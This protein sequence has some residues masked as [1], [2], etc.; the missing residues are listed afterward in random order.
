M[1]LFSTKFALS[2][3]MT[4]NEFLSMLQDWMEK[5]S[6]YTINPSFS[7]GVNEYDFCSEDKSERLLVYIMDDTLSVRL[8]KRNDDSVFTNTYIMTVVDGI[9]VMFIRLEKSLL[10]A[11]FQRDFNMKIPR[12]MR[13]I[14]WHEYGG[15]DHGL[16]T[17]D[18]SFILRK[19][20]VDLANDILSYNVEFFNPIVYVSTIK[21]TGRYILNYDVLASELLGMAHVVVEGSPFVSELISEATDGKNPT[22][23]NVMVLLPSGETEIFTKDYNLNNK[24]AMYIRKSMADVLVDD[25]FSFSKIRLSYLLSKTS[26]TEELSAICDEI[27][28]DKDQEIQAL[29]ARLA[30][31]EKNA[32]DMRQKITSYEHSFKKSKKLSDV[33]SSLSINVSEKNLYDDEIKDVILKVLK[34]EYDS[35]VGDKNLSVSRKFAVLGD[36]LANN[37]L[38]G[39]DEKLKSIFKTNVK[40]G[41]MNAEAMRE[42]ERNGFKVLKTGNNHF[43]IVFGDDSRY[44]MA[45]SFSPSDVR[46]G[47]NLV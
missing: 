44:Q 3:D 27:I 6:Y 43:K 8:I 16:L 47:E 11:T 41:T 35:M 4:Q 26:D 9:S 33:D 17:D 28:A 21:D 42:V 10:R 36:I 7:K 31:C 46:A 19:K 29:K 30:A 1:V 38:T 32:F 22:D 39:T 15:M 13:E 40:D 20:D 2:D 37:E 5:S 23:G 14:F 25:A 34:R 45:M 24:I 12:L 18:K